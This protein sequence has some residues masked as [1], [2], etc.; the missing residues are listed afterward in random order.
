[1]SRPRLPIQSDFPSNLT[2]SIIPPPASTPPTNILIL[3]H[4]LGDTH[5]PFT[6]L[7]QNLNLRE[8]ACISL[9]GPNPIPPLFIG[10]DAAPA[11]HWGDDVLVDENKGEIDMD[12]GFEVSRKVLMNIVIKEVLLEKC[13]FTRRNIL[14]W[15]F[16]Q[17]GMAILSCVGKEFLDSLS[18]SSS[19]PN[20]ASLEYGGIISIG[21]CLPPS[22]TFPAQNKS[23]NKTPILILSGSRSLEVTKERLEKTR[24][25]FGTVES[26]K[27]K[28][29]EDSM[30]ASREEILPIM[31]FFGRRL[32]SVA[33][34]PEG[35]VELG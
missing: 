31:E 17:G 33:G 32:R 2:L 8:T 12:A 13:G 35:A 30:P 11:F 26:V 5:Q 22:F 15:G 14:F 20:E 9:R 6:R 7:A 4:G 16:G 27:W 34:V 19:T 10:D 29:G 24:L 3:L 1:M 28:K 18:S 23:R 21:A 25:I